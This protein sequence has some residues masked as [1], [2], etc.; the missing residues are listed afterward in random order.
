[1]IFD[2]IFIIYQIITIQCSYYLA[3][4]TIWG[5]FHAVFQSPVTL[6]HFF[7]PKYIGFTTTSGWVDAIC[8][9]LSALIG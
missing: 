3:M 2:P 5:V 4:G 7:T 9:F 1:M 6:D 8:T